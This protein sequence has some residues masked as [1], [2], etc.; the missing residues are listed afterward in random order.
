MGR[1]FFR[2]LSVVFF[3]GV[4]SRV[5]VRGGVVFVFICC[6]LCSNIYCVLLFFVFRLRVRGGSLGVDG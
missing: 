5:V 2:F 6:G 4:L 3:V 1:V